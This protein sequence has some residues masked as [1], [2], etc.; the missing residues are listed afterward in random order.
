MEGQ[1]GRD[2]L[3]Y[4]IHKEH[5]LGQSLVEEHIL[6]PEVQ[7]KE[8]AHFI[9]GWKPAHVPGPQGGR[10]LGMQGTRTG[11]LSV[12]T[13]EVLPTQS[14]RSSPR[15]Q[16]EPMPNSRLQ[17]CRFLLAACSK[18]D[19]GLCGGLSWAICRVVMYWACIWCNPLI[20]P[21]TGTPRV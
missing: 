12:G 9:L 16:V 18:C 19:S 8:E 13:G 2:A 6:Q 4:T 7:R 10:T 20:G 17:Y 11:L 5:P 3:T 15:T 14:S 1:R 21:E